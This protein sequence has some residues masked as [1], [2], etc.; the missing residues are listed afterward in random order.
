MSTSEG[1]WTESSVDPGFDS[2]THQWCNLRKL[3]L[4]TSVF[5]LKMARWDGEGGGL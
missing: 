1:H 4:R 5:S 3:F 2:A